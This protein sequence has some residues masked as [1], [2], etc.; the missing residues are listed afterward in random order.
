MSPKG[1]PFARGTKD[2]KSGV[3][4]A[5]T[6]TP[7]HT[8]APSKPTGTSL[9]ELANSYLENLDEIGKSPA[10]IFS[11]RI[12]LT[13]A[14]KHFG[15]NTPATSLTPES[16]GEFFGSDRGWILFLVL[17]WFCRGR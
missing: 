13:I 16:V 1:V 3:K 7:A 8:T 6:A 12:D 17:F 10:T 14:R 4:R 15:D 11:Y 9:A 5:H 2:T